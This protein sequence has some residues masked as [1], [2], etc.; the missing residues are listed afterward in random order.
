[1][2][3]VFQ[4][5]EGGL[6]GELHLYQPNE[7]IELK[8]EGIVEQIEFNANSVEAFNNAKGIRHWYSLSD[9]KSR[10]CSITTYYRE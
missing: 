3:Q 1:M 4:I 10:R 9:V 8:E 6:G 5:G 7:P 2:I